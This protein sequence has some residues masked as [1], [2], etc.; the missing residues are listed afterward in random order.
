MAEPHIGSIGSR[1][2]R[3]L[4]KIL[5][6]FI[7]H[8]QGSIWTLEAPNGLILIRTTLEYAVTDCLCNLNHKR[9]SEVRWHT[10]V[11]S[12]NANRVLCSHLV[13]QYR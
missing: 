9:Q 7:W 4:K 1:D 5:Q 10:V 11:A 8:F 2:L 12:V 6:N 3:A 13:V